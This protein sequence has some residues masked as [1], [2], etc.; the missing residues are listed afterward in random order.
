MTIMND[1]LK[2]ALSVLLIIFGLIG[3]ETVIQDWFNIFNYS[4]GFFLFHIMA[5]IFAIIIGLVG[6][7]SAFYEY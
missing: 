2:S 1:T 6:L 3:V 4:I 7:R 5:S